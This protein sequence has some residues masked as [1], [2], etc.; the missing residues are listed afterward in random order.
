MNADG[1]DIKHYETTRSVIGSFYQ[2]YNELGQ[3]FLEAVYVEALSLALR[4]RMACLVYRELPIKVHFRGHVVGRFRADVVVNGRVL[5]EVKAL[6]RLEP[7]HGAQILNYLRA[8]ALEVG[9]LLNFGRVLNSDGF[10][11]ITPSR[12][13]PSLAI[14]S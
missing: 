11:S 8:T 5:V 1:N 7:V 3:G 4:A 12:Q 10:V 14:Q 2:V 6:P 13:S 9:L